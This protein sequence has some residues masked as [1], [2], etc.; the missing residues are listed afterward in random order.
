MYKQIIINILIAAIAWSLLFVGLGWLIYFPFI[1]PIGSIVVGYLLALF[2]GRSNLSV[3]LLT[4]LVPFF[5]LSFIPFLNDPADMLIS[6]WY[7][8]VIT[9]CIGVVIRLAT[10]IIAKNLNKP[11]NKP[12]NQDGANGAPPG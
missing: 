12:L 11:H 1:L 3:T 8:T 10:I 2:I 9:F 7:F 6:Y 5:P 4:F